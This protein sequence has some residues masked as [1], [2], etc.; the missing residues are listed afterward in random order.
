MSAQDRYEATD[1]DSLKYRSAYNPGYYEL[2]GHLHTIPAADSDSNIYVTQIFY[3]K[4][5]LYSDSSIS[6]FPSEYEYL[7][8]IYAGVKALEAK[9]AEYT[10]DEEDTELTQAISVNLSVLQKQYNEA[11]GLMGAVQKNQAK[12]QAKEQS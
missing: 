12:S 6:N 8:A 4:N 11:F 1:K 9:M 5:S 7:V 10:I 3:D 2:D